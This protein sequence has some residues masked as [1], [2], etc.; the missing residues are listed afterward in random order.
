VHPL[1]ERPLHLASDRAAID[2][3]RTIYRVD[4]AAGLEMSKQQGMYTLLLING[5]DE[6]RVPAERNPA[7]GIVSLAEMADALRLVDQ[8]WGLRTTARISRGAAHDHHRPRTPEH[9]DLLAG[10]KR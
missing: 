2:P 6:G 4:T 1:C 8:R 10:L 3:T 5:Y 9:D 7:G